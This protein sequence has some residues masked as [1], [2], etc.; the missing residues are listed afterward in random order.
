MQDQGNECL[1]VSVE[2]AAKLAGISRGLAYEMVKQG[3][4]P[5][6]H[7]GRV[8]RIPKF[9]LEK[10]LAEAGNKPGGAPS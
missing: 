6:L 1:T 7:F 4:I 9:A 3:K 2:T 5:A 10:L 8:I